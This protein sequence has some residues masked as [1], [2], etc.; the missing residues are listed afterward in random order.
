MS[1][2]YSTLADVAGLKGITVGHINIR[3]VFRKLEEIVRILRVGDFDI[4]C[5]TESW[6]NKYVSDAMLNIDGY[7]MIR[8][9]RSAQSGKQTGGG[10][11][12]YHKNNLDITEIKGLTVCNQNVEIL[13]V[14]LQLKQTRPQYIGVVY[15]PP[16][17][18]Y[19]AAV[20]ILE[21]NLTNLNVR[22]CDRM[23]IGDI[24]VDI[25]KGREPKTRCYLDFYKRQ[26]LT[27]LIK[28]ITQ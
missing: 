22:N 16:D 17:G 25:L 23:L 7:N 8:A 18:D 9:D 1:T 11:I 5:I 24:N 26:G 15:R 27:N 14:T 28:G 10:I 13:W 19:N 21:D 4:L 3:S 6:L 20:D 2:M 12:L